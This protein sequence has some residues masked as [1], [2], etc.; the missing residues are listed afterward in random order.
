MYDIKWIRENSD[1]FDRGLARRGLE[2]LARELLSI[3]ER[4]RAAIGRLEAAQARRNAASK[5]I[6]EAKRRGDET[7]AERLKDEVAALKASIPALE[8]EEKEVTKEFETAL[9]QVPNLPLDDVPDGIDE[10]D[11]V[12]HH[13][14]GAMRDYAFVPKQHFDL[15]EALGQ[16]DF[17]TA[18]KL[19]GARFVV[20]K[21]KLAR[22]ERALAQFMF[23]LHTQEHGY[24]EISPP[25]L[26]RDEVMF[27]TAQLP[28]FKDDQFS[29]YKE[30]MIAGRENRAV[31]R[32]L[33]NLMER[34]AAK[35]WVEQKVD[36]SAGTARVMADIE[37][38]PR[39]DRFWLIPTAEVPLTNLV[40]ESIVDEDALPMRFTACTPCFRAEAGAAGK[41]TRGMLRQH[42]FTKVGLVSLT[43]P[44]QSGDELER[45]LSCAEEVLRRLDIH[46]RVVTLCTGEM[47]FAAQKTYDIEVWLPGQGLYREISSCSICGDFQARRMGARYR[48]KEGRHIRHVHTLNGSG[49]AVGRTLIAVL[50]NYQQADGTIAVP[51]VLQSYMD[52][53]K[54]IERV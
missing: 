37:S 27:G 50:E 17:E 45:M 13:R 46:Y 25:I 30:M 32:L 20:L 12:E 18:A 15:G 38:E 44:E 8:A 36:L 52:G 49:L 26:V 22:L 53:I 31:A 35:L 3:D 39:E 1:L 14:F 28:K 33:K 29:A 9:A 11:N 4:R 19:S 42:Q 41:D 47:G 54:T 2:S 6:G 48:T 21:G 24:T 5:E 23:D 10:N 40:R 16:M 7:A 34:D 43:T 51:D